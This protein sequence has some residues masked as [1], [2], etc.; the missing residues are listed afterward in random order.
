MAEPHHELKAVHNCI[1]ITLFSNW[2]A[3]NQLP[4]KQRSSTIIHKFHAFKTYWTDPPPRKETK[5]DQTRRPNISSITISVVPL[6]TSPFH[7]STRLRCKRLYNRPRVWGKGSC[8]LTTRLASQWHKHSP[9]AFT[10]LK[11]SKW[12]SPTVSSK[13]A[14]NWNSQLWRLLPQW[15][16]Y[17][18][19]R[20]KHNCI[21]L[22]ITTLH[23]YVFTSLWAAVGLTA[24]APN[25]LPLKIDKK[26]CSKS[27]PQKKGGENVKEI[28]YKIY[29][30]I[31]EKN[32][33]DLLHPI[34]H[35][36]VSIGI[37]V[38]HCGWAIYKTSWNSTEARRLREL[39]FRLINNNPWM[40]FWISC[41]GGSRGS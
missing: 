11:A 26:T 33:G 41:D 24:E 29:N 39:S 37:S 7:K 28:T 14:V 8:W 35:Y 16:V 21:P 13:Y 15:Y 10:I 3:T 20:V 5:I 17:T 38:V 2:K 19:I 6:V 4:A 34:L 32:T 9:K 1:C 30:H 12:V 22:Q 31:F 36:H 18:K 23:M 25:V 27:E 40:A